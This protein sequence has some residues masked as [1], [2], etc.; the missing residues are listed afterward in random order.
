MVFI[1]KPFTY[2]YVYNFFKKYDTILLSKKYSS[3]TDVLK[4]KC[5]C[6]NIFYKSLNGFKSSRSKKCPECVKKIIHSERALGIDFVKNFM[7]NN[8]GCK[9]LSQTY[10]S[11]Q[12]KLEIEC[13]CGTV[14]YRSF[15]KYKDSNQR[16]C[17]NCS[18]DNIKEAL[19]TPYPEVFNFV[20]SKECNLIS[21]EYINNSEKIVIECPCGNIF[22]TTFNKFKIRNQCRCR[23]CSGKE[24]ISERRT[25][26]WLSDNSI[27]F[28][29]EIRFNDCSYKHTLPFDFGIFDD[30]GILCCLI[31]ND[32]EAHYKAIRYGGISIEQAISNL[33]Q[34]RIKD[35]I[36]TKYCIDNN[37]KLVRIPYW[38][39]KNIEME[40]GNII[41][42][43]NTMPSL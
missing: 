13:S 34:T 37:I 33:K 38:K 40:L 3:N 28:E 35:E 42:Q 30:A 27:R 41:T 29:Q 36:K 31:E 8:G 21:K 15:A 5:S 32:G 12:Q 6:G 25:R 22:S 2:E 1:K 18:K 4:L 9:L 10:S 23:E 14:Y 7:E 43:D 20:K 24:S 26:E 16:C 17:Q 39:F 11:N 19:K